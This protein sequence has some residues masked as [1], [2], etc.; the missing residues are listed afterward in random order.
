MAVGRGA[1]G[2]EGDVWTTRRVA[3]LIR[4]VVGVRYHKDHVRKLLRALDHSPLKPIRRA[5][6]RNE[7]AIERWPAERWPA[8]KKTRAAK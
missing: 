2:F 7:A 1:Y 5:T 4:R 6:Q 3:E 8:L